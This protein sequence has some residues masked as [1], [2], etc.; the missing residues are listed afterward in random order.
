MKRTQY[1]QPHRLT[2]RTTPPTVLKFWT[3]QAADLAAQAVDEGHAGNHERAAYLWSL[4]RDT[5]PANDFT[6][7]Y[8][9]EHSKVAA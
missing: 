3:A 5:A 2:L 7:D 4:A 9:D 8:C 1:R 6:R